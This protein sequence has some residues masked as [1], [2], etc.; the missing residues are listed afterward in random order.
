MVESDRGK[1]RTLLNYL[2]DHNREHSQE[3]KALAEGLK[4]TDRNTV[5]SHILEAA[6]L[7]DGSTDSLAKALAELKED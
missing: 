1:L 4:G 7:L 6:R 2:I 5:S 3:L